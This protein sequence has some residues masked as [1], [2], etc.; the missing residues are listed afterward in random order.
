MSNSVELRRKMQEK[1]PLLKSILRFPSLKVK[2][3]V[4]EKGNTIQKRLKKLPLQEIVFSLFAC[5]LRA[6]LRRAS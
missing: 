2:A 4:K 6:G 5:C 1:V 3:K